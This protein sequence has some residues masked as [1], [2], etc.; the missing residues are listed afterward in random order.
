MK[1]SKILKLLTIAGAL[2]T[3]KPALANSHSISNTNQIP[4]K[5][6]DIHKFETSEN[7]I[8]LFGENNKGQL[9]LTVQDLRTGSENSITNFGTNSDIDL[10]ELAVSDSSIVWVE[11]KRNDYDWDNDG[12]LDKSYY[13]FVNQNGSNTQISKNADVYDMIISGDNFIVST[14]QENE[15]EL[16]F[17]YKPATGLS[18]LSTNEIEDL[19]ITSSGEFAFIEEKSYED[20]IVFFDGNQTNYYN[21]TLRDPIIIK[22]KSVYFLNR[23]SNSLTKLNNSNIETVLKLR[24]NEYLNSIF[25]SK[26]DLYTVIEVED[27]FG[28]EYHQM[29]RIIGNNELEY[30]STFE[31]DFRLLKSNDNGIYF[32]VEDENTDKETLY[33]YEKNKGLSELVS[34]TELRRIRILGDKIIGENDNWELESRTVAEIPLPSEFTPYLKL[35][36]D[37]EDFEETS[38]DYI[39]QTMQ[40]KLI[41][42]M[43][44][45]DLKEWIDVDKYRCSRDGLH[46]KSV[47]MRDIF[48]EITDQRFQ[49]GC[50]NQECDEYREE[51]SNKPFFFK[52]QM[53][54]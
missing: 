41:V 19:T 7:R 52:L 49:N 21:G 53:R 26:N 31:G 30:I 9:E 3:A 12:D 32:E 39:S 45:T 28:T 40:G 4:T 14:E 18:L 51:I 8:A 35:N 6:E 10:N 33:H 48:E 42:L 54:Y 25:I 17:V 38:V 27:E 22:D 15:Q 34:N 37:Q 13:V 46:Q 2:N 29:Y 16:L 20:Q 23:D 43:A 50:S 1:V 44:S 24:E 5:I 36:I 47:D 11:E